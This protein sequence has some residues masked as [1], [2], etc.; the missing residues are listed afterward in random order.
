MQNIRN[1]FQL[2]SITWF[3]V[4]GIAKFYA[5][6]S[7]IEELS[8]VVKEFQ[9]IIVLG[10]ASNVLISDLPIQ[11]CVV[12]LSSFFGKIKLI[13]KIPIKTSII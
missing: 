13:K 4:G 12:K 8:I 10:N 6:P 5:R 9:D 2:S 7:N 1:D 11:E 3:K